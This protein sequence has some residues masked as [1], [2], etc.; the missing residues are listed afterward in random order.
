[1]STIQ[2]AAAT[3]DMVVDGIKKANDTLGKCFVNGAVVVSDSSITRRYLKEASPPITKALAALDSI[4]RWHTD[5]AYED[6]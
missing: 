4:E 2:H 5:A 6:A 1:M 3:T